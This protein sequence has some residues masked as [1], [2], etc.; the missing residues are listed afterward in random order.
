MEK[1]MKRAPLVFAG[2]LFLLQMLSAEEKVTVKEYPLTKMQEQNRNIVRMA[3]EE[4]NKDLPKKIDKYTTLMK[5]EGKGETLLYTFEI[6]TGAKNDEAIRKEDRTRMQRAV[7]NGICKSS[8][9]FLDAYINIVYV[10]MSAKSKKELFRF[11]IKRAD[12]EYFD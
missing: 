6:N 5:I 7:T 4:L 8:K 9:R 12:C 10:Y 3:S 2:V 1:E 11:D